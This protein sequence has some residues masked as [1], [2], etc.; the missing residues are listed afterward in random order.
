MANWRWNESAGRYIDTETGKF[1]SRTYA[2]D[3]IKQSIQQSIVVTDTLAN[4]VSNGLIAVDDWKSLMRSEI[5]DEY[6]RQYLAGI[7]GREMMT[8]A[9]WGKIGS[10]LKEQYKFLD[11]FAKEVPNLSEAQIRVRAAMY[12]ESAGQA[13]E[14]AHAKVALARGFDTVYWNVDP[15][16]E[17]CD[18]CLERQRQGGSPI[19][20][21]GGF[22]SIDGEV[23]PK[24]CTAPCMT[25]DGCTL[26][27][28]NSKTGEVF[29]EE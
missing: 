8:P 2:L 26:T 7:G 27:Y 21:R 5:R 11:G 12:S 25:R 20:P 18:V 13:N 3:L 6:I 10:L 28:E 14:M 23:F 22:M 29:E 9:D 4:Y 1:I 17:N 19:G 15:N 16:L 24:D